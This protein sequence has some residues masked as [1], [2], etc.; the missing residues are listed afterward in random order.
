VSALTL[1]AT[2][3]AA[4]E[5]ADLVLTNGI[6]HTV[7]PEAP[8]AQAMAVLDGEIRAVG[9]AEHVDAWRGPDTTVIDLEGRAVI[10]GL[11]DAH[12]HVFN[13]GKFLRTLDLVGTVSVQ[14]IATRVGEAAA[15]R[16]AGE[17]ILG[18]GWD[19]N[20][21]AVKEF[22]TTAALESAAPDHA[23]WL[24]RV[25]GHA[26]WA[27][28]RAMELAGITA[29]TLD[30]DGGRIVRDEAG[31]PTGIFIDNAEELIEAA[32]PEPGPEELAARLAAA[33]ERMVSVGLTGAHDMGTELE[34]VALF[35]EWAAAGRLVPRIVFYLDSSDTTLMGALD[36]IAAAGDAQPNDRYFISGVKF[37]GDGALGSRGAALLEPYRDDAGNVGLLVTPPEKL[38]AQAT[39]ALSLGLQPAIHAIGDRGNRVALE[40]I[41]AAEES[42]A[43]G[44]GNGITS[45]STTD[46]SVWRGGAPRIEHAQVVALD[47]I[48]RFAELG[49][50]ASVQPTHATSDMYW[51]EDRVGPERIQGA[52]AWRK[53]LEAGVPLACG[54]DFPVENPD[55]FHGLHAA[56]TRQDQEGWPRGGW[57]PED[58]LTR[59]EALA[60]FTVWAADAAGMADD[61][62]SLEVG[63]RADF[64]ILDRDIM[65][66]PAEEI[67]ATRVLR[68]VIDGETVYEAPPGSE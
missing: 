23:V 55:P 42:V 65:N 19:Q 13:L 16:P 53:M 54:S 49:V 17:W 52:Y 39:R 47:D 68:T 4:Q 28:R 64:L 22:P 38:Q 37:Y 21:W 5:P 20:D 35:R 66:I 29:A 27:N 25:D 67:W 50:I 9:T 7:D 58:R 62:G 36:S 61:I 2:S 48:P 8:L 56:I 59:E 31:N 1:G 26:G 32:V 12:A 44:S 30:P 57:R 34:E 18:R 46:L 10:P 51:A 63:K 41:A 45:G 60:C 6:I 11:I 3:L 33:Q 24:T 14:E 15:E 40:A 43:M